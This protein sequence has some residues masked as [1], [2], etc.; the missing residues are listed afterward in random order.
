MEL[1]RLL[2]REGVVFDGFFSCGMN[3]VGMRPLPFVGI[4]SR[5]MG[6]RNT[7]QGLCAFVI[8]QYFRMAD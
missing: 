2:R 3:L 4:G 7:V 1:L 8:V 6:I 5:P